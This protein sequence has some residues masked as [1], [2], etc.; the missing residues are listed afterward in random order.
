MDE[1]TKTSLQ[2]VLANF[3][4]TKLQITEEQKQAIRAAKEKWIQAIDD[5]KLG[6]ELLQA[7]NKAVK[8]PNMIVA[9]LLQNL[10]RLIIQHLFCNKTGEEWKELVAHYRLDFIKY[11]GEF[12]FFLFSIRLGLF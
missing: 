7:L 12:T 5:A 6:K 11:R 3:E 10:L 8:P 1:K 9:H 2:T 4:V